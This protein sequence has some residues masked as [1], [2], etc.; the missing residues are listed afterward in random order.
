MV[1]TQLPND[2]W[3]EAPIARGSPPF[4]LLSSAAICELPHSSCK[5]VDQRSSDR[6]FT[7]SDRHVSPMP[8]RFGTRARPSWICSGSS[9]IASAQSTILQVVAG[10]A[11]GEQVRADLWQQMRRHLDAMR[12]SD[13]GRMDPAAH[14]TY[15]SRIRHDVVARSGGERLDHGLR[16]IDVL[17]DLY[18]YS[19]RFRDRRVAGVIVLT[20]RLLEPSNT[21]AF[22]SASATDRLGHRQRLVVIDRQ[23]DGFLEAACAPRG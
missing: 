2:L 3:N 23:L 21:F 6:A 13:A 4:F 14:A 22:E 20:D 8:G 12:C 15:A 9:R 1:A 11:R 18:Q 5:Q 16:S 19:E 7:V 10:R 17:T